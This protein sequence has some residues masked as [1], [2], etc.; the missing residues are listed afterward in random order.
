MPGAP[1]PGLG[2]EHVQADAE[3]DHAAGDAEG[4]DRD[5]EQ[6]QQLVAHHGED[7]QHAEGHDQRLDQGAPLL[8]A[9]PCGRSGR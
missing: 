5:A 8:G 1:A 7:G 4:V 3:E 2:L 9:G 6:L